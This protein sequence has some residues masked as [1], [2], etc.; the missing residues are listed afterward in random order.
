MLF[1]NIHQS[2]GVLQRHGFRF[3]HLPFA[4]DLVVYP[5]VVEEP[6]DSDCIPLSFGIT[7]PDIQSEAF[8]VTRSSR[9]RKSLAVQRTHS[10]AF[11]GWQDRMRTFLH[12][13]G[14]AG[15]HAVQSARGDQSTGCPVGLSN[16]KEGRRE[17]ASYPM[18]RHA[19][20]T[21][22][23]TYGLGGFNGRPILQGSARITL[24]SRSGAESGRIFIAEHDTSLS[25]FG[26]DAEAG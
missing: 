15:G 23:Y 12:F 9:G 21:H 8:H 24:F 11:K 13:R 22:G 18:C 2:V 5:D 16:P 20:I 26:A 6:D 3:V 14:F 25:V 10:N 1:G 7:R 19:L 17:D 4:A